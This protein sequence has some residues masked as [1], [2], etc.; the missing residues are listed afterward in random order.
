VAATGAPCYRFEKE[1]ASKDSA[2]G[3]MSGS[4]NQP[5]PAKE[6]QLFRCVMR[7]Y[8]FY[9]SNV[10]RWWASCSVAAAQIRSLPIAVTVPRAARS[11]VRAAAP[12]QNTSAALTAR[13]RAAS[14]RG[15]PG[16]PCEPRAS[17]AAPIPG[18]PDPS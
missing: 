16:H 8:V 13:L 15:P 2:F 3:R 18:H 7:H 9:L 1:A 12:R 5:L 14:A 17:A 4:G 10:R 11:S 6:Q